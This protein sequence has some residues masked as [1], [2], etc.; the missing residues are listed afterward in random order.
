MH[1]VVVVDMEVSLYI[2]WPAH[3][4]Y[5]APETSSTTKT[6]TYTFQ[7]SEYVVPESLIRGCCWPRR[8]SFNHHRLSSS[9]LA[10]QEP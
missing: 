2:D 5:S 1:H 4:L 7:I 9:Q 10:E 6:N 3:V 8:H